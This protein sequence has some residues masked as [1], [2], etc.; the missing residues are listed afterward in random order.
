[1]RRAAQYLLHNE[2]PFKDDYPE[3]WI[4]KALYVPTYVVRSIIIASLS[5]YEDTFGDL[6]R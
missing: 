3:L 6:I 4:A 1:L 5:M 2:L